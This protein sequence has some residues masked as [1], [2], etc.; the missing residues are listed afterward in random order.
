MRFVAIVVAGVVAAL[1]L[2]LATNVFNVP[3]PGVDTSLL[4]V[5]VFVAPQ[6]FDWASEAAE[7]FNAEGHRLNRRPIVI[8]VVERDGLSLYAQVNSASLNPVPA[9]WIA[10]GAFTLD[11]VNLAARQ[12]GLSDAFTA[13]GSV[14]QSVMMWGGFADR[15]AALDSNFGGL[16][17]K[18]LHEAAIAR[19]GWS[20][21]GGQPEWGFFKLVL[22]DPSKSSEALAALL[23][24]AAE[25]HGK[26]DLTA[27]DVNDARF[28]Q[29]AHDLVDAVPN[30]ANLGSEPGRALAVRGA[31]AGDAGQLLEADWLSA[32][33]GMGNWQTPAFRYA[34]TAV[35]FDFPFS[36]WSG[37]A[38]A[39]GDPSAAP[40]LRSGLRLTAGAEEDA[41]RREAARLFRAYLLQDAQQ[42]RAE[43]FGLRPA[44][45]NVTD[46]EGSLFAQWASLGFESGRPPT[47]SAQAS[48]DAVLAALRWAERAAG[49]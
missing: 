32:V 17:W 5:Q 40:S 29:W 10:E 6:A 27:A 37:P 34:P 30:F 19:D 38:G 3:L 46:A 42:R 13:E 20:S 8:R 35:T 45:G 41:S 21:L 18:A 31:S 4:D 14:A 25:Y 33:E 43:A 28:Q 22:A 47:S 11:L 39:G 12:S 2:W 36:V 15:I 24:A 7:R 44:S 49:R 48:A 23:A 9:A 16:T 26:T 1:L